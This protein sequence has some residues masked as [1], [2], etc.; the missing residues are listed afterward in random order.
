[1]ARTDSKDQILTGALR[2]A[3]EQ[4]GRAITLEAA[5]REAGLTKP[6]LM[7]HYGTKDALM[8]AVVEHVVSQWVESLREALGGDPEGASAQARM[9]AYVDVVLAGTFDRADF[10]ITAY[11][12]TDDE[13][14]AVWR[15]GLAPWFHMPDDLDAA[16]RVR[17]TTVRFA[18]DGLWVA[19]ATNSMDVPHYDR[20]QL[21]EQLYRLID[22][23]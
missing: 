12:S 9:R 22:G 4:G 6:G 14:A 23:Q 11:S 5:A 10:A 17:L 19:D 15:K 2:L 21:R 1:M 8:L 18:A 13:L 20:A 3:R 16:T 7:Y